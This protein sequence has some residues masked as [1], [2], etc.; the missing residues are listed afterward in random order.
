MK[1]RFSKTLIFVLLFAM[2]IGLLLSGAAFA[3]GEND[4]F[5]ITVVP[6]TGNASAVFVPDAPAI[7]PAPAEA[8]EGE[9]EPAPAEL[10]EEG[11][12]PERAL[13]ITEIEDEEVPL[14]ALEMP[15]GKS[16]PAVNP[17]IFV[18]AAVVLAGGFFAVRAYIARKKDREFAKL[19]G[20]AD[21]RF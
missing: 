5:T 1:I 14:S 16:S 6:Q 15:E 21:F 7:A 18:S 20:A 19:I 13:T 10:P 17:L 2:C 12:A 8:E 4:G 3:E 9:G 11:T